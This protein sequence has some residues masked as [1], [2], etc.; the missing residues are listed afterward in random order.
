[1]KNLTKKEIRKTLLDFLEWNR[2]FHD[3]DRCSDPSTYE[4]MKNN[5][6]KTDETGLQFHNLDV[7]A[8]YEHSLRMLWGDFKTK[9][10]K[11]SIKALDHI[12]NITTEMFYEMTDKDI[13]NWHSDYSY[14]ESLIRVKD[15]IIKVSK[16]AKCFTE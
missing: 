12:I 16:G 2:N 6:M 13:P 5:K 3:F 4:K 15:H 14:L 10:S 9:R 7:R 11:K 1:M 8:L